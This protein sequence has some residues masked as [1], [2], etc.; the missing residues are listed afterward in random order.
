VG[1]E[2]LDS[3]SLLQYIRIEKR[4]HSSLGNVFLA[5]HDIGKFDARFQR[6]VPEIWQTLH[7][8][9]LSTRLSPSHSQ[10][11]FHGPVGLFWLQLEFDEFI[12]GKSKK[13]KFDSED[14][15]DPGWDDAEEDPLWS[16]WKLCEPP[17]VWV[18]IFVIS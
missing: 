3:Q 13:D 15:F 17:R 5:M 6:K 14:P 8:H 1:T 2:S 9:Q 18:D 7:L 4:T 12:F 10:N 16:V 11:Y